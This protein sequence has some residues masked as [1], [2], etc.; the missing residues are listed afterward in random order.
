MT[1]TEIPTPLD[2]IRA[3][4]PAE[5]LDLAQWVAWKFEQR[6]GK[7]TKVPYNPSTGTRADSTDP[8]TWGTFDDAG[9]ALVGG[10]YAGLGFV[11]TEHDSYVGV[12]LDHCIVNGELT[13]DANRWLLLLDS[14]SYITPSMDGVRALVKGKKAGTRCKNAKLGIEIYETGRFFTITGNRLVDLPTTINERQTELD[15]LYNEIFLSDAQPVAQEQ[16]TPPAVVLSMDDKQLVDLMCRDYD[17]KNLFDGDLSAHSNDHSA[18][19]LALCNHLA[20]WTGKDPDRMNRIF[21]TSGLYRKKWDRADY[22]KNTID[23]ALV[24]CQNTYDPNYRDGQ[25]DTGKTKDRAGPDAT[26]QTSTPPAN[27]LLSYGMHDEGNAQCVHV[28]YN[29]RF[30][31][32]DSHGW[33]QHVGTHWKS[34]GSEAAVERAVTA[35]L[36]KR[37]GAAVAAGAQN[38]ADLIKKSIPDRKRVVG[39]KGQLQS[40][41]HADIGSFDNN[42]D[43]LNCPNGVIDLRKA[44]LTPH[45][46]AQR[47]MYCVAVDYRADCDY[48][49]FVNWLAESTSP[50]VADWLQLAVG[51]SLTGY[52]SEEVLFYLYGPPRS[53]KGTFVDAILKMLGDPV[54]QAVQFS[55]F[56]A[57][58]GKDDQNFDLAPLKSARFIAASESN[59]NERFNE[60]KVK[61]VTGGDKVRCAFKH[62]DQFDYKPSYKIWLSSNNPVNADPDDDAVWGRV[63]VVQFPH[64]HL[65]KEDKTLKRRMHSQAGLEAI[66]AWAVAG[67]VRWYKLGAA[68]LPELEILSCLKK[69]QRAELDHV[70]QWIDECCQTDDPNAFS[71]NE[72]VNISYRTWCNDNGVTPKLKKGLTQSLNKKGFASNVGWIVNPSTNQGKT[73]RGFV[74]LRVL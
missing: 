33:L 74:G 28:L 35:T 48:T 58:R 25:S 22:S 27:F 36:E 26:A 31:H 66:F 40:L 5:L 38:Y 71:S 6:D 1:S 11:V 30:L 47:F 45:S 4:I 60:A 16:H 23:R 51:Y 55:T 49:K 73:A 54:G 70:Q 14:Y 72:T 59:T 18:A 65:G 56:T 13:D 44:T 64:S 2:A 12:D 69:A 34:E 61:Q 8:R 24:G 37:I 17:I 10:D 41:V 39:A 3:N 50:E 57:D 7:P 62:K 15:T 21:K 20:F 67:A 43:L 63:R 53:G 52:T 9:A 42:P 32:T 19:D 68:G 29:G 46:P